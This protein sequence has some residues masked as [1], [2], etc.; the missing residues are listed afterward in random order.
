MV[1]ERLLTKMWTESGCF[2][3]KLYEIDSK[4]FFL[5]EKSFAHLKMLLLTL[6]Q[7]FQVLNRLECVFLAYV[8]LCAVILLELRTKL[9]N[10]HVDHGKVLKSF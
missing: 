2:L 8:L 5:E 9:N 3:P 4:N 6:F 1:T 7:Y 10:D